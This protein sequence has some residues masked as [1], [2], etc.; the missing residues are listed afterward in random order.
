MTPNPQKPAPKISSQPATNLDAFLKLFKFDFSFKNIT[1]FLPKF[2]PSI[3]PAQTKSGHSLTL[4]V[5]AMCYLAVLAIIAN[6]LINKSVSTWTAD[7]S[8]QVTVQ[9]KPVD[10]IEMSQQIEQARTILS[11]TKGIASSSVLSTDDSL[12]L[13]EPWLGKGSL[14][15]DLPVPRLISVMIDETSPPDFDALALALNT[16]VKGAT[17]DT[18]KHWQGQ[19]IQSAKAFQWV[20]LGILFLIS[21]TTIAIIVFATRAATASNQEVISVLH[22]VGA[23]DNFIAG[24]MQTRFVLI[25]LKSG[26]SAIIYG[27]VTYV[28]LGLVFG[29]Y[30]GI[31]AEAN[32]QSFI[33]G[34]ASIGLA[35]F[36]WLFTVPLVT[37][38]ICYLTSRIVVLRLLSSVL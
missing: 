18:H 37:I 12:K 3:L 38:A 20:S 34:P 7:I 19:I 9:I 22:L 29:S 4:V 32:L 14:L 17:L 33:F 10:G 16:D 21:L 28:A 6:V 25:G 8:R 35:G 1:H 15:A 36:L 2:Q 11:A 27:I 30:I 24:Q 23:H 31:E 26:L 13:L 5:S